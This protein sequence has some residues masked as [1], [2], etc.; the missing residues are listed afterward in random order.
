MVGGPYIHNRG[1]GDVVD[2]QN[3]CV[4]LPPS[5]FPRRWTDTADRAR[6]RAVFLRRPASSPASTF[7]ALFVLPIGV[8]LT[9]VD[10]EK[11]GR[12]Q[13]CCPNVRRAGC[14]LGAMSSSGERCS[15]RGPVRA[16]P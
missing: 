11:L 12:G 8:Q 10:T 14:R 16:G 2:R 7:L 5:A 3:L 1:E 6:A 13:V 9:T 15:C 4:Q